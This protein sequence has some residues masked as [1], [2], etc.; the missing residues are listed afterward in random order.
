VITLKDIKADNSDYEISLVKLAGKPI[1][2]IYGYLSNEFDEPVFKITKVVFSKDCWLDAEGE[3]D[4][5]YLANGKGKTIYE[6][7][8]LLERLY[9]ED[10]PD[11][12]EEE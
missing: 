4:F 5:P 9:R 12:E 7:E 11:D 1:K 8:E 10:N 2:D 3:H 6:D